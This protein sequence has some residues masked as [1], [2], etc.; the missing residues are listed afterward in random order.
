MFCEEFSRFCSLIWFVADEYYDMILGYTFKISNEIF[1]NVLCSTAFWFVVGMCVFGY[2]SYKD[3]FFVTKH[4]S[5]KQGILDEGW[6][7]IICA[8]RNISFGAVFLEECISSFVKFLLEEIALFSRKD[9][10]ILH[11]KSSKRTKN[12]LTYYRNGVKKLE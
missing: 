10:D 8:K 12:I 4:A 7:E 11:R 2:S 6:V 3:K 5:T 1:F 9:K